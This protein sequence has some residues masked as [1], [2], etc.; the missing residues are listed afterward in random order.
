MAI[1]VTIAIEPREAVRLKWLN[2]YV[3]RFLYNGS[4]T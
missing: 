4:L 3:K 1:F 2:V